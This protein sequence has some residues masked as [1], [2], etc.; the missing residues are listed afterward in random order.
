MHGG[1]EAAEGRIR[2]KICSEILSSQS[3]LKKFYS[4]LQLDGVVNV[5]THSKGVFLEHRV[6]DGRY[7]VGKPDFQKFINV[8]RRCQRTYW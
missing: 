5:I 6:L 3:Y 8:R 4:K 2:S 7:V 1:G